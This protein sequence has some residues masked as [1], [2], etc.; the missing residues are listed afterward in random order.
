MIERVL[1]PEHPLTLDARAEIARR[2]G[3]RA[4]EAADLYAGVLPRFERILGPEHLDTLAV[5]A[6]LAWSTG[7]AEDTVEAR[8]QFAALLPVVERVLGPEDPLT[9][10]VRAGVARWT[11]SVRGV[12]D[13]AG[14]RDQFA[15]LLPVFSGSWARSTRETLYIRHSV[16]RWTGQAGTRPGP[17]T[18]TP[19]C[20]PCESG[21]WPGATR[22]PG[23]PERISP[24]GPRKR[25]PGRTSFG[26]R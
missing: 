5:R 6:G 7:E 21:S 13:A 15:A 20:C 26:V 9:L 19:R 10:D 23:L 16:A 3:R 2:P 11:G 4:R 8:D 12:G 22:T 1:G 24:T 18:N 17:G 25:I 14:A